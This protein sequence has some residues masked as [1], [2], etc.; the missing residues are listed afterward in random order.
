MTLEKIFGIKNPVMGMVHLGDLH[1]PKGID[2]VKDMALADALNL[3]LGGLGVDGLLVEN[4]EEASAGPFVTN[5][6]IERMLQVIDEL[7]KAVPIPVGVNVLHNDYRAAFTLAKQL[8]LEFVQ[9]DVYADKAR[10]AFTTPK[11]FSS[12]L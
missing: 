7:K 11:A 8:G 3:H 12:M 5:E 6:T 10:T 4:W 1:S 9:L 2:Y